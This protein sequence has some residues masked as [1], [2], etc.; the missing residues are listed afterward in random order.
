LIHCNEELLVLTAGLETAKLLW[1][2]VVSTAMAK[3][4]CIDLNNFY[5]TAKLEFYEYMTIPFAYFPPWIVNQYN[6]N[7]H[8][9]NGKVHLEL[10]QAVRGLSQAGI[11]TNKQLRRKLAPFGYKEHAN[12]PGLWYHETC[13]ILFTLAVDDFGIKYVNKTDVEHLFESLQA[14]YKL[15]MDWTGSILWDHSWVELRQAIR[16]HI[17]AWL[18]KKETPGIQ[19]RCPQ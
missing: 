16:Q 10:R 7:L 5:L 11:P 18:Y 12:T 17:N 2:S 15:T 8:A 13:P 6:L 9:L 4:M 19:T 14:T 1:N 3:Y